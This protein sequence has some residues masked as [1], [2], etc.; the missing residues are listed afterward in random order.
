VRQFLA[1]KYNLRDLKLWRE[2]TY[3]SRHNKLPA[4]TSSR[5]D[6]PPAIILGMTNYMGIFGYFDKM[7]INKTFIMIIFS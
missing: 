3:L 1:G 7:D 5:H 2:Y 6:N 4:K